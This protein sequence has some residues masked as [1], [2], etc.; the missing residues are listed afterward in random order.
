[1]AENREMGN[2]AAGPRQRNFPPR[3]KGCQASLR[4]LLLTG[5]ITHCLW[6]REKHR[7]LTPPR[8]FLAGQTGLFHTHHVTSNL[9]PPP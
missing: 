9:A 5:V 6:G 4:V 1:M 3:T 7:H 8:A 2:D